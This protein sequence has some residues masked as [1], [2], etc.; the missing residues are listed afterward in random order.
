MPDSSAGAPAL[1]GNPTAVPPH[2]EALLQAVGL[3]IMQ[4]QNAID[5]LGLVMETSSCFQA[6]HWALHLLYDRVKN[7]PSALLQ[8]Q[9]TASLLPPL[10]LVLSE[11][12]SLKPQ[13]EVLGGVLRA[14]SMYLVIARLP[15]VDVQQCHFHFS[16]C[17]NRAS[18]VA[19]LL[20]L[21][22]LQ[23]QLAGPCCSSDPGPATEQHGTAGEATV[24]GRASSWEKRCSSSLETA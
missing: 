10:M 15:A 12:A 23:Q 7:R 20:E 18:R 2:H 5:N 16:W 19:D 14:S 8:N 3:D 1:H 22:P 9:P 4:M 11:L 13:A 17:G 24:A 6:L 21:V